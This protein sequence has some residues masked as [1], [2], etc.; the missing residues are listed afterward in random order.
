MD[1]DQD[2]RLRNSDPVGHYSMRSASC[3]RTQLSIKEADDSETK[4]AYTHANLIQR[5]QIGYVT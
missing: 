1:Q 5:I 2:P 4:P 3:L